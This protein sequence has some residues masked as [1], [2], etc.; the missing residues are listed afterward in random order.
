MKAEDGAR[1]ESNPV[2]FTN[3]PRA[4][5]EPRERTLS[6]AEARSMRHALP[7]NDYGTLVRLIFYTACR[8]SEIAALEWCA[9]VPTWRA[10]RAPAPGSVRGCAR[11]PAAGRPAAT[12][13]ERLAGPFP[14]RGTRVVAPR[15]VAMTGTGSE[16]FANMEVERR[17]HHRRARQ[18]R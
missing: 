13:R 17:A 18:R 10:C 9:T 2:A 8:R 1:C 3:D 12:V 11:A 4:D 7:S 5:A 6:P 15:G 14:R 16:A